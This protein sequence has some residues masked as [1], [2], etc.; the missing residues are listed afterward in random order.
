MS[1]SN[2][3]HMVG[4]GDAKTACFF[5]L[6]SG[7]PIYIYRDPLPGYLGYIKSLIPEL[8]NEIRKS[9]Q[10]FRSAYISRRGISRTFYLLPVL[11]RLTLR[12]N[13][14]PRQNL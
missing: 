14:N 4:V 8:G 13:E 12:I 3:I 2:Y 1:L 7:I 9:R 11:V 10:K 6:D 5:L